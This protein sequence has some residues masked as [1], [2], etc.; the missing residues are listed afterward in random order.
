LIQRGTTRLRVADPSSLPRQF[1]ANTTEALPMNGE[2]AWNRIR[3][4]AA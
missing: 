2:E 4:Q 1:A 3:A